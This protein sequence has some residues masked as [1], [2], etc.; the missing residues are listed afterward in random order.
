MKIKLTLI[1]ICFCCSL[2]SE[3]YVCTFN[4]KNIGGIDEIQYTKLK[5]TGDHFIS[6]YLGQ[7]SKY[8][9]LHENEEVLIL[10]NISKEKGYESVRT[11][12]LNKEKGIY[13]STYLTEPVPN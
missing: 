1:L 7:L 5:R 12:Y 11:F 10:S 9:F 2:F 4:P 3:T 13:G 8:D 6:D